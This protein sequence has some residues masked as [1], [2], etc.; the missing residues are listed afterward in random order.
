MAEIAPK[1]KG[2]EYEFI[3][4]DLV[5]KSDLIIKYNPVHKKVPVL[6]HNWE[7]VCGPMVL[8]G[9][10]YAYFNQWNGIILKSYRDDLD[11]KFVEE[12]E[13]EK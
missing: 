9:L 6:L 5:N 10:T 7:K 4:E 11:K 8:N 13:N 1:L 3:E 2:V 12:K